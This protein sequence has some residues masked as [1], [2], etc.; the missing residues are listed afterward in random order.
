MTPIKNLQT[1]LKSMKPKLI[2]GDYVFY[3]TKKSNTKLKSICIFQEKEGTTLILKKTEADKNK[4]KYDAVWNLITLTVHSDLEAVGFLAK[5]TEKLAKNNISVNVI[6]AY[7]H[8]H[9]FILKK[10]T[11]KVLQLL[12]KF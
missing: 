9:L 7:Y 4:L 3:T 12:K 2:K 1:L 10:D 8:D 11:K 6:S 5:I